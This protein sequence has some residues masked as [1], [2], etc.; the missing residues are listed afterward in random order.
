MA[1]FSLSKSNSSNEQN[2]DGTKSSCSIVATTVNQETMNGIHSTN[3]NLNGESSD[4]NNSNNN[5]RSFPE[6]NNVDDEIYYQYNDDDG[7]GAEERGNESIN[8][9]EMYN[10]YDND[11]IHDQFNDQQLAQNSTNSPIQQH[12]INHNHLYLHTQPTF[13]PYLTPSFFRNV[14]PQLEEYNN[15]I[16]WVSVFGYHSN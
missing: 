1:D 10:G 13:D 12:L 8:G 4:V 5:K 3:E 6:E 14:N 2:S 16:E 7:R 15:K 11:V 9:I